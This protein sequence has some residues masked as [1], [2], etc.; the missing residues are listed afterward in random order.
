MWV[1]DDGV[2]HVL[3]LPDPADVL[4]PAALES[5]A[6]LVSERSAQLVELDLDD[7]L[8]ALAENGFAPDADGRFVECAPAAGLLAGDLSSLDGLDAA[9]ADIDPRWQV[10][11]LFALQALLPRAG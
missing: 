9:L 4:T 3:E 2:Q 7:R 8:I 6:R 5:F 1:T 11:L 10:D